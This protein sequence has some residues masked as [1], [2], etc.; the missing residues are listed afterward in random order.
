MQINNQDKK[1]E[2][3]GRML[4]N[5]YESGHLSKRRALKFSFIKGIAQG[6]GSAIGAGIA[7]AAL[8][9]LFSIFSN[10]PIVGPLLNSIRSF[11]ES[12]Q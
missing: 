3:L 2:K 10:T 11:I 9:F 8:L 12:N 5:I 4:V 6:A 1:Y 7:I